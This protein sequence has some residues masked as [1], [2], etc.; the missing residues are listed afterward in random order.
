MDFVFSNFPQILMESISGEF[1]GHFSTLIL[2]RLNQR[3]GS[4]QNFNASASSSSWSFMLPLSLRLPH[5]WSFLLSLPAPDR[6][7]HFW[8]RFRFQSLSSKCFRFHKNLIASTSLLSM[9]QLT[10]F[11]VKKNKKQASLLCKLF[12]LTCVVD[13][14]WYGMEDDFST[15]HTSNFLSFHFHSI[16]KI[17]RSIF[18]SILPYQRNF[19][20]EAM[21]RIFRCFA[22]L[23]CCKQPLVKVRQQYW[24]AT[25]GIWYAYSTWFNA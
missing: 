6:I 1:R 25:T 10:V 17:F 11:S 19:R 4:S 21:Q 5:L 13:R 16:L 23:Q 15:F 8:V 3:C 12:H 2:L 14:E 18:H 7:S 9:N 20:L 22:S 24:D